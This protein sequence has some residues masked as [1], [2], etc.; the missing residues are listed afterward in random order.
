M[1]DGLE[2]ELGGYALRDQELEVW[3][4]VLDSHVRVCCA[5]IYAVG[6]LW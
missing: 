6:Y 1:L 3:R 2:D 4:Q 5:G